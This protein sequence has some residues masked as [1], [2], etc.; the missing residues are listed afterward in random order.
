MKEYRLNNEITSPKVRLINENGEHLGIKSTS[1]AIKMAQGKNLDLVEINPTTDPPVAKI[2]SFGQFK[3]ML[4]KQKKGKGS[5][6]SVEEVKG[7]RLSPS[8]SEHDFN[9]RLNQAKKF[10]DKNKKVK[11]EIILRGREKAH[12][13]IAFNI[14]QKFINS[15][16]NIVIENPPKRLGSKVTCLIKKEKGS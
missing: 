7:I 12:T 6:A 3:Y 4:K 11:I 14:I 9:L 2:M 16:E 8:I 15:L 10:L 1:E 5:K 13:N